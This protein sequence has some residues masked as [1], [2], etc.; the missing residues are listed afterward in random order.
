MDWPATGIATCSCLSGAVM[1][2]T[3]SFLR[4][5]ARDQTQVFGLDCQ[6]LYH[7][8]CLSSIHLLVYINGTYSWGS[9]IF[10]YIPWH[11]LIRCSHP[12][13]SSPH[14]SRSEP[15]DILLLS[16]RLFGSHIVERTYGTY[17]TCLSVTALPTVLQF[18]TLA[19]VTGYHSFLVTSQYLAV[20]IP[21]TFC[22]YS[23]TTFQCG[24]FH[25]LD[26]LSRAV[27]NL[28]R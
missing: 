10:P 22:I 23:S 7:L 17:C 13:Q 5:D 24:Q 21:Y 19:D 20:Q 18:H 26:I 3:P 27:I 11:T 1:T 14:P 15:I 8:S 6:A 4:V 28:N 12:C 2:I 9:M 25:L 16:D